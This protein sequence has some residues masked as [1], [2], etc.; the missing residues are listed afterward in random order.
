MTQKRPLPLRILIIVWI[1]I[2]TIFV[3][4]AVAFSIAFTILLVV[5]YLYVTKPLNEVKLL[6]KQN[7]AETAFMKQYREELAKNGDKDSLVQVF[8]PFDSISD[9]LK[10]AVLAAE[11]DAFYSHPGFSLDAI[12]EAI[13]HNRNTRGVKHG[14]STITQQLAKNLF[15]SPERSFERK[16]KELGYTLLMEKYLSKDRIFELYLNYAQWGKNVFGCEAASNLYYKKSSRTLNRSEA[17]RMAAVLAMPG[18]LT[19]HHTRSNFMAKRLAVIANNLYLM[20]NIDDEGYSS[21]TGQ[22][23]PGK[24]TDR[25]ADSTGTLQSDSGG[26][27]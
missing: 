17:A 1:I 3:T 21:L 11:D 18:R 27:K 25:L 5:G 14:A 2:R 13:D 15:L 19:P 10:K 8:V 7:P 12:V 23:P 20:G 26:T 24:E 4:Y 16:F 9:N 6:Q 22:P